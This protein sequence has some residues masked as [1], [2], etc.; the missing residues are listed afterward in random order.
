MEK[1]K[2]D[3]LLIS[4]VSNIF[5]LTGFSSFSTQERE[6]YL[7]ISKNS[8]FIFTDGRYSEA[9]LHKIPHFNLIETKSESPFIKNLSQ[10]IKKGEIDR[11]GFEETSLSF[12]EHKEISR[13]VE[14]TPTKW[15][16]DS[17]RAF[18]D[19]EEIETIRKACGIGDLTFE[20]ILGEIKEGISEKE[21]NLTLEA[22]IKKSGADSSFHP[23]VAFGTNSSVPHHQ[24]GN[25]KLK[26]NQIVLLDFGV[27]YE[28]YCSDMTR[29][30]FFGKA[31]SEFR[32]AYQ[33]VLESQTKA[34][35]LLNHKSK[36]LNL[37]DVD[38]SARDHIIKQR[39]PSIPHS[40]GHQIGID[41][42]EEPRL[43][44]KSKD[45]VRNGMVFSIEPG[46][47][48]PG[49]GGVRI[50]DLVLYQNGPHLL[51]SSNRNLIEL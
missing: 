11:V 38:K 44:P 43:S 34:I 36:I 13:V 49:F 18:K 28:G 5:Y 3:A 10:I 27:K 9:V 15:V 7:L 16:V 30:V 14:L 25:T 46:I 41:V 40:L 33:T 24:S 29:T 19:D 47:Y 6:A 22:F 39:Y 50:E 37:K 20:F 31:D 2:I 45:K 42:H 1:N 17:L 51:T 32:H 26:K 23:I 21:L 12:A 48:I 8:N 4:D 35:E